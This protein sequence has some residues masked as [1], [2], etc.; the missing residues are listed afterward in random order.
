MIFTGDFYGVY[1][2]GNFWENGAPAKEVGGGGGGRCGGGRAATLTRKDT[3]MS[4]QCH[5]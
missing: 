5:K 1:V 2:Q 3:R 4:C